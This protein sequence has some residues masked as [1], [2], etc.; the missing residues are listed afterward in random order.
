[1]TTDKAHSNCDGPLYF[2]G[3][4]VKPPQDGSFAPEIRDNPPSPKEE[5]NQF[6]IEKPA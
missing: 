3:A 2:M 5:L 1:M 4:L 6:M